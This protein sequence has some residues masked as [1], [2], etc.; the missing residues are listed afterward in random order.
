MNVWEGAIRLEYFWVCGCDYLQSE[1][2]HCT[3]FSLEILDSPSFSLLISIFP[4]PFAKP[5]TT[6]KSI[7]NSVRK[8]EGKSYAFVE[9]AGHSAARSAL[10]GSVRRGLSLRGRTVTV[11]WAK[12]GGMDRKEGGREERRDESNFDAGGVVGKAF[13]VGSVGT[14]ISPLAA[15]NNLPSKSLLSHPPV[16]DVRKS[17]SLAVN[18]K[19]LFLTGLPL[20]SVPP[21]THP[22]SSC[23]ANSEPIPSTTSTN[24][25][26]MEETTSASSSSH[27][28]LSELQTLLSSATSFYFPP[29]K[30]FCFISFPSHAIAKQTL[31]NALT[32][33]STAFQLYNFWLSH[34][35]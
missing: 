7:K 29:Q 10:E 32:Q 6:F 27:P 12:D 26:S 4:L 25:D 22:A 14:Y 21:P 17:G 34:L 20:V 23:L 11:G 31:E 30:P 24:G 8:P 3:V 35:L 28:L 15:S 9:F 33:V 19:T 18:I 5:N 16:D 2:L 13:G 1:S